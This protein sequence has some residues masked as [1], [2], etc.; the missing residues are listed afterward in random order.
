LIKVSVID[1]NIIHA[2]IINKIETD[3][4]KYLSTSLEK[5][6][7]ESK[8]ACILLDGTDFDGWDNLTALQTHLSFISKHQKSIK[9]VAVIAGKEWQNY[10]AKMLRLFL[11]PDVEVFKPD[12][13]KQALE[14]VKK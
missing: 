10:L 1:K 6:I 13:E 3:D 4:F 12:Q 11:K 8:T 9:K 2:K 7:K 5:T 14:W